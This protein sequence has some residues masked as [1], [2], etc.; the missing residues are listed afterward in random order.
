VAAAASRPATQAV[1]TLLAVVLL[2]AAGIYAYRNW[3]NHVTSACRAYGTHPVTD[4]FPIAVVLGDSYTRGALLPRPREQAWSTLLGRQE[5]WR[6]YAEG[7]SST[8]VTTSGLCPGQSFSARLPKALA[9]D[10]QILVVQT[11]LNDAREARP[12]E[13]RAATIALLARAQQ[14]PRLIVVGPPAAPSTPP[15]VLQRIDRELTEACRRPRCQYVSA[16]HWRLPFAS[17]RLHLLPE[18]HVLLARYVA[19]A[20]AGHPAGAASPVAHRTAAHAAAR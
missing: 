5:G 12:G 4:G 1:A 3:S 8:G 20:L 2:G 7:V 14:V 17:D 18:G 10:P 15:K 9:H 13:T 16:L 6:T 11:G 19:Q